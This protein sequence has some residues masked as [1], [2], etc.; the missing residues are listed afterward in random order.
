MHDLRRLMSVRPIRA[1]EAAFRTLRDR[2]TEVRDGVMLEDIVESHGV[3]SL[4]AAVAEVEPSV[5]AHLEDQA[6]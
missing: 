6:E 5:A 1:A 2:F 4:V 3:E